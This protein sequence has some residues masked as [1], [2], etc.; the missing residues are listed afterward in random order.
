[1]R[2]KIKRKVSQ[3]QSRLL[4]Q[5]LSGIKY[6]FVKI[7]SLA[8]Y[9]VEIVLRYNFGGRYFN[10]PILIGAV[11]SIHLWSNLFSLLSAANN[12][13]TSYSENQQTP[14]SN[15]FLVNFYAT[16]VFILGIWH[17]VTI[18]QRQAQGIYG[19]TRDNGTSHLTRFYPNDRMTKLVGEPAL[20]LGIGA[21]LALA[22]PTRSLGLYFITTAI[23]LFSKEFLTDTQLKTKYFDAIDSKIDNKSFKQ[24]MDQGWNSF[25]STKWPTPQKQQ[26]FI[27]NI[28]VTP[29]P[30]NNQFINDQKMIASL[31]PNLQSLYQGNNP[32]HTPDHARTVADKVNKIFKKKKP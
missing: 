2:R 11:L 15:F 30:A 21:I 7:F 1:M 25:F 10:I 20:V 16:I 23:F 12:L 4:S 8:S 24:L 32:S 29:P 27:V 5:L 13:A 28:P 14:T 17:I 31:D 18:H 9:G 22:Y 26:D 19:H 6:V 3:L